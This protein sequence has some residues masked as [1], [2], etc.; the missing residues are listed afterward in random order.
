MHLRLA[1]L[2]TLPLCIL[3]LATTA[4]AEIRDWSDSTGSFTS[5]GELVAFDGKTARITLDNGF[6]VDLPI[7]RLSSG[8][9]S[10][11][12]TSFP[13]GK[14]PEL[15]KKKPGKGGT[16]PTTAGK[17][18][19]KVEL[20]GVAVVKPVE[21]LPADATPL[22]PGTHLW[23][24]VSNPDQPL[25]GVDPE[26]SKIISFTDNKGTDLAEGAAA[27]SAFEFTP[28]ADG[29]SGLV[30]VHRT[31][32]PETKAVRASLKGQLHLQSGAGDETV[33]V[34]LNLEITLGL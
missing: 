22:P 8:D 18:Q 17:A 13:D 34:P 25:A 11:L 28:L 24:M 21:N 10:Y 30:H 2:V 3:L 31:Q 6:T 19:M 4:L 16:S 23:L 29:K 20:A 12:K 5:K 14:S 26:K 1:P 9:Q 15:L 7:D 32:V 33:A 27:G